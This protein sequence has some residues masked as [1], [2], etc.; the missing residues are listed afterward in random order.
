ML[1]FPAIT[2]RNSIERPESI[3]AGTIIITG[4]IPEVV[5]DSVRLVIDEFGKRKKYSQI[6][7]EYQVK[8]TSWRVLKTIVGTAKLSNKWWGIEI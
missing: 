1:Y 3:D 7:P 2:I 8:N 4:L 6:C 5:L